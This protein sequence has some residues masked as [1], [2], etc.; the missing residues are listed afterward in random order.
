MVASGV[1]SRTV[2]LAL[3]AETQRQKPE[4]PSDPPHLA[5][6]LSCCKPYDN[7]TPK[8]SFAVAVD[9]QQTTVSILAFD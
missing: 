7:L 5:L 3:W 9:N 1:L 4:P 2:R 8:V 6:A